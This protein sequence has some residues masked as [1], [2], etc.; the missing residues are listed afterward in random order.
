MNNNA[1]VLEKKLH[2]DIARLSELLDEAREHDTPF[3]DV[4][5][6][7]LEKKQPRLTQL[8]DLRNRGYTEQEFTAF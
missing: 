8:I 7:E 5:A 1:E 2:G 4:L 6:Q 3:V